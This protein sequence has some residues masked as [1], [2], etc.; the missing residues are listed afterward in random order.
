MK[1]KNLWL[2]SISLWMSTVEFAVLVAIKSLQ[3]YVSMCGIVCEMGKKGKGNEQ[4]QKLQ[5]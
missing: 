4:K 5:Q 1:A 3:G 2:E